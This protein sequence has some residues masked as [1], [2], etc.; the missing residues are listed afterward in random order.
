MTEPTLLFNLTNLAYW[1]ALSAII[2]VE[3]TTAVGW[4]E[5]KR[6]LLGYSTLFGS[7]LL[8]MVNFSGWH[9]YTWLILAL[10]SALARYSRLDHH[11][12]RLLGRLAGLN[13]IGL[14]DSPK[15]EPHRWTAQYFLAFVAAIPLII[16]TRADIITWAAMFFSLGLCGAIKV[17]YHALATSYQARRLRQEPLPSGDPQE[18]TNGPTGR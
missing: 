18:Q 13:L 4:P 10:L 12:L 14:W 9:Y 7:S 17:G 3:T 5:N 11:L 16:W 8:F 1:V 6:W 15:R 2:I